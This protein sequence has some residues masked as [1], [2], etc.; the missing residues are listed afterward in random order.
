MKDFIV[1]AKASGTYRYRCS[2]IRLYF[3]MRILVDG[4][5]AE[6]LSRAG[7]FKTD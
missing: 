7:I 1:N 3:K 2:N 5:K 4:F 6:F